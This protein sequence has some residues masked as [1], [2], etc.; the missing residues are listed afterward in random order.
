MAPRFILRGDVIPMLPE[1]RGRASGIGVTLIS[2]RAA[3]VNLAVRVCSRGEGAMTRQE[4]LDD[5]NC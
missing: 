2:Q 3:V 5:R 4:D 1:T